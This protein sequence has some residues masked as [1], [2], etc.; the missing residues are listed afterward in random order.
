MGRAVKRVPLDFDWP[1][2]EPWKG[3]LNPHYDVATQCPDCEGYRGASPALRELRDKWY[4]YIAFKPEDNGS[5]PYLPSNPHIIR[6]ARRSLG[7]NEHFEGPRLEREAER[8]C[9]RFNRQWSHHLNDQ[10][11][12]DLLGSC[13][14]ST[15]RELT[16]TWSTE[17]G[18]Q[19]K[20][21][22]Y[23]PT[24]Q[25]VNDWAINDA[26]FTSSTAYVIS[27]AR[28]A[29]E[30]K[31]SKCPHCKGE[32]EFWPSEEAKAA[33]N[34]WEK[35]EPPVGEGYQM[36]ETVSEGSPITPVF[37][38][39]EELAT[40]MAGTRFGGD[41]GTPYETWLEFVKGPGWAPS[42]VVGPAGVQSG[43]E[44]VVGAAR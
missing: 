15:L 21:P 44:A 42:L 29:R 20:E 12:A 23:V 8:L 11:V 43:V 30:G 32:G 26:F 27:K 36:W 18:W 17:N 40:F 38:T 37:A 31:D 34:N 1:L 5:T 3:F 39:A 9:A 14:A 41:K 28:L 4:G 13:Y 10:D 6:C 25:E 33:Y 19:P 16:H 24:A 22:A 35:E 2:E 7:V